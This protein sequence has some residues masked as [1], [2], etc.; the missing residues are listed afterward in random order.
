MELGVKREGEGE[1]EDEER[2]AQK[3]LPTAEPRRAWRSLGCPSTPST[4]CRQTCGQC[5][6]CCAANSASLWAGNKVPVARNIS[7]ARL[8]AGVNGALARS[9]SP[10]A[11]S[12]ASPP[13]NTYQA[14]ANHCQH[15]H[16]VSTPPAR[17]AKH[18]RI[19]PDH[20]PLARDHAAVNDIACPYAG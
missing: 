1:G 7:E 10:A 9:G 6:A 14:A 16:L 4:P 3:K 11:A 2:W 15:H 20:A 12:R 13:P 8:A 17:R 5:R 19:C 18:K